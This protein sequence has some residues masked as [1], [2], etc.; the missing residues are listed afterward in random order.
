[1][2]RI[3]Y[4]KKTQHT[5]RGICEGTGFFSFSFFSRL[6]ENQERPA[7]NKTKPTHNTQTHPT[8]AVGSR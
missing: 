1:M 7:A 6:M 3:L 4:K 8:A 2:S 5:S